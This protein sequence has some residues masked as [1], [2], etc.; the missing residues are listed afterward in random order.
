MAGLLRVWEYAGIRGS[1]ANFVQL[2]SVKN[3]LRYVKNASLER[4]I[5]SS[6]VYSAGWLIRARRCIFKIIEFVSY[7]KLSAELNNSQGHSI[8]SVAAIRQNRCGYY[9]LPG[10]LAVPVIGLL[11]HL[12]SAST[13]ELVNEL[14]KIR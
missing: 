12:G 14:V 8:N 4:G 1:G 7:H 5:S 2:R 11:Q 3:D 9:L 6:A 10:M 13:H